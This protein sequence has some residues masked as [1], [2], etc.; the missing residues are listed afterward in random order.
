MRER[1]TTMINGR[2]VLQM[3]IG[4]SGMVVDIPMV[5]LKN[6]GNVG[7]VNLIEEESGDECFMLM[8]TSETNIHS[9]LV[10]ET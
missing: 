1:G 6:D 3:E 4:T 7:M 9:M 8:G 10:D 5:Q 2:K